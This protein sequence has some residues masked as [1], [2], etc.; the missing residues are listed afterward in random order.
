MTREQYAKNL[1]VPTETVDVVLD[2]DAFNEVDDQFAI[3]YLL[4]AAERA[5]ILGFCAAPFFNINSA[6]PADGMERSYA[7]IGKLLRLSG[8]EELCEQVYR[9]SDRYLPNEET[10]VESPAARFLIETARAHTPQ[11]PLYVVAIGAITNVASALLLAP[12]IAENI[13]IVWLGGHAHHWPQQPADEFNMT[14]DIAAA[15]VV[16][17]SAAPLVQLPCFGVVDHFIV[18]EGELKQYLLEKNPAADYLA[19]NVLT[20]QAAY[21]DGLPWGRVIWDVTAVAW[22]LNDG[23]RF[24]NSTVTAAPMP[25]EDRS[26]S[27]EDGAK[28]IRCIYRIDRTALL[29][30]M[31]RRIAGEG[32]L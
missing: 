23:D 30:D 32:A 12:D 31:L 26:Y 9:G 11:H 17:G 5:R 27:F 16:F 28:P 15:R 18:T 20:C 2:T 3:V 14:Q 24:M 13:V 7:E 8:R 21:A 22:L 4:H 19:R 1:S 29:T 10:A 6:S 25:Q